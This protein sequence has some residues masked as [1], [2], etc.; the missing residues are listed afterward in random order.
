M[1]LKFP[2]LSYKTVD[3][4]SFQTNTTWLE[5]VMNDFDDE[6]LEVINVNVSLIKNK[7]I[8]Y[9]I[10]NQNYFDYLIRINGRR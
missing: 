1:N 4:I 7:L 10:S 6:K 2:F 5:N 3:K 9:Q 8:S